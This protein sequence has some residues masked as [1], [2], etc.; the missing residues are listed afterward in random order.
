MPVTSE[1]NAKYQAFVSRIAQKN[2]CFDFMPDQIVWHYT[3]ATG[4]LGILQSSQL[5]A[6]QVSA[7]NDAKET[8]HASEL[9][10]NAVK[11]LINERAA[12]PDV[13]QF[14]ST[15]IA[16]LGENETA[17]TRSKFFVTCFS[18]EEDDLSQWERYGKPS[19]YAVGFFARGLQREPTSTLFRVVYEDEKHQKTAKELAEASVDFYLDGLKGERLLQPEQW[20][21]EFL[22]AWDD[23]VYKLAP[24]AKASKWKA[25]NEYRIVHELKTWEF[26]RVRFAA[27]ATM[28]ARYIPL[29]TPSWVPR[30]SPLLPIAKILVGPGNNFG[31]T[32]VS[33][34]LLLDQMGYTNIPIEASSI[35]LQH[36]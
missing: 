1:E 19:G 26:S 14:L 4:F 31:V 2:G 34:S 36:L 33:V 23:W 3:N 8:K 9:F 30:R 12:E 24:L 16:Y 29:D 13:V 21:K 20:A 11:R 6:T 22:T 32:R 5:Y 35:P 27:K 17:H 28:I 25:E 7:L 15:V 10:G 18:G